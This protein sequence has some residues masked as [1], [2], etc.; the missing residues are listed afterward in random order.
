MSHIEESRLT[1]RLL[2][3]SCVIACGKKE[4]W[5]L[6][7]WVQRATSLYARESYY[8]NPHPKPNP[9]DPTNPNPT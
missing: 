8:R 2:A 1:V 9:T 7:E 5:K 6:T 3:L 4:T